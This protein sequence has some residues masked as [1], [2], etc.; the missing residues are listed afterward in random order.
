LYTP[1]CGECKFCRSGKTNLCGA[2]RDTQGQGLM[3]GG[4][5]RLSCNG[6]TLYHYM[7]TSTFAKY[8]VMPKIALA[9]ISKNTPLGKARMLGCGITTGIG[10]VHNTAKVAAG[11]TVAVFGLGALGLSVIQGAVM[12][13]ASRII[14]IDVNPDKFGFAQQLGATDCVNPKDHGVPIQE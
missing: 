12:A 3:P 9:K 6:K 4:T 14:A 13:K 2:I 5:S 11:D 10:A 7:G 1:E 8:A